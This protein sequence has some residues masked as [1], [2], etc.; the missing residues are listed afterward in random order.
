VTLTKARL[1]QLRQDGAVTSTVTLDTLY[2]EKV[3]IAMLP[4][5]Q[6][7][8]LQRDGVIRRRQH[9]RASTV[10]TLTALADAPGVDTQVSRSGW[11]SLR[12]ARRPA[13]CDGL[14]TV[15]QPVPLRLS[16]PA[17]SLSLS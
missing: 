8:G 15:A 2:A 7:E 16:L 4:T 1:L 5:L 6:V 11:R 9:S 10:A 17:G 3:L 13:R 12:R 14:V